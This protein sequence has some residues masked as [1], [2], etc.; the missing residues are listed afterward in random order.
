M[1]E[2]P[3]EV[4][5]TFWESI[6]GKFLM[7]L[8]LFAIVGAIFYTYKQRKRKNINQKINV[9]KNE[10]YIVKTILDTEPSIT[11]KCK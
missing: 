3:I 10:F 8:L 1:A 9:L 4:R 2:L 11:R 5:P 6:W 7:L